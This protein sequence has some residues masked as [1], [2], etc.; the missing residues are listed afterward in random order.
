MAK[1]YISK[2]RKW[3]TAEKKTGAKKALRVRR[4][5]VA[6]YRAGHHRTGAVFDRHVLLTQTQGK[7]DPIYVEF[8]HFF[9][10]YASF[11]V[12]LRQYFSIT[13]NYLFLPCLL[14]RAREY[15]PRCCCAAA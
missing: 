3:T 4:H 15:L 7:K 2:R 9:A 5:H 1:K 8:N 14:Y 10:L 11:A 12:F 6:P 13:M